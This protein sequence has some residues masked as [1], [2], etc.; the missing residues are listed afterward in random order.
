MIKVNLVP[1]ELLAKAREKQRAVQIG[2]AIGAVGLLI[3]GASLL[4]VSRLTRLEAKLKAD[5]TKLAQLSAVVAKVKEVETT[6]SLLKARLKVIED[7]DKG[8][9]AYPYFMSDFVRSVPSGVR[10]QNLSTTGGSN[11]PIKLRVNAEA[12]TNEDIALWVRKM[13]E[14]NRFSEIELGAV[15]A[16]ETTE[17]VLRGFSLNMTYTP[18][19]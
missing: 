19:L 3:L 10:V 1:A 9:R 4:F 11:A 2:L 14:S 7:L 15:N 6:A 13:E 17:A 8:R 18:Q 16:K 5:E 12:R